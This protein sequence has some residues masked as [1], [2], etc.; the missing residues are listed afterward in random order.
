MC[1]DY[2]IYIFLI[3]S[4]NLSINITLYL[5]LMKEKDL[6]TYFVVSYLYI[7]NNNF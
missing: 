4:K 5:I 6:L 1:Y 7:I 2:K 3:I